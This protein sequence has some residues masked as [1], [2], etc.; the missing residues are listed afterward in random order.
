MAG[1]KI[2][3]GPS[4]QTVALNLKRMREAQKLTYTEVS[5]KLES[6]G[7][8][9]SP[10][11]VRRMEDGDRRVDVDDL[12]ALSVALNV[13]PVTLLMPNT[14]ARDE[15][16][17]MTGISDHEAEEVWKWVRA[18]RKL[19]GSSDA[20]ELIDYIHLVTPSWRSEE[21][22]QGAIQLAELGRAEVKAKQGDRAEL[23][24]LLTENRENNGN[25]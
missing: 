2:D 11:A 14:D 16:V 22:I 20:R 17:Q 25:D 15:T 1:Q 10:L 3:I 12:V 5:R 8:A 7:R 18:D 13:A 6:I 23:D 4:G 19:G 9:I 24:S 21:Y